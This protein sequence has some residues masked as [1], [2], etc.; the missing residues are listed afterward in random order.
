MNIKSK[1][2]RG[3]LSVVLQKLIKKKLGTDITLQI[4][5]VD[6]YDVDEGAVGVHLDMD[7]LI[8]RTEL[9]KLVDNGLKNIRE[10]G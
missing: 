1:L 2:I 10:D 8:D 3:L 9:Q 4:N 5:G 7:A 6:I